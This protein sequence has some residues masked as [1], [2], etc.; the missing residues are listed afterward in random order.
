M[1][2]QENMPI[3]MQIANDIREQ[4]IAG[5][6]PEGEKLHSVRELSGIYQVTALTIQRTISLLES[7]HIVETRRGV[8]SF[9]TQSIRPALAQATM[10]AETASFV[11]RMRNMGLGDENIL[12]IVKEILEHE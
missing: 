5:K 2:F 10:R 7:E 12:Q 3:Y 11:C 6:L 1:V 4:I 8:G 9:V